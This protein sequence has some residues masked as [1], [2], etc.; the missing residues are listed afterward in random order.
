MA[1]HTKITRPKE[2]TYYVAHSKDKTIMQ[3]GEVTPDLCMETSL[4][5]IEKTTD[6]AIYLARKEKLGIKEDIIIEEELGIKEEDIPKD[7]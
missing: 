4:E 6:K 5:V 3:H 1:E 2:T 7:G